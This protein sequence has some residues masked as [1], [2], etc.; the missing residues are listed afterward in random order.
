[1]YADSV[2]TF[3]MHIRARYENYLFSSIVLLLCVTV[4]CTADS[5]LYN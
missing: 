3:L 4:Y 1:V 5:V 2:K